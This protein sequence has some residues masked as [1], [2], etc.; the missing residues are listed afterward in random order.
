MHLSLHLSKYSGPD[1]I[2]KYR[3]IPS[4][5]DL[6][7]VSYSYYGPA[8]SRE[9]TVLLCVVSHSHIFHNNTNGTNTGM[10]L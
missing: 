7:S 4:L 3:M 10:L 2:I 8:N 1:Y 5:I 6:H 9:S